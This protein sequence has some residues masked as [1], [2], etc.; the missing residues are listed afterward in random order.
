MTQY[1]RALTPLMWG[2]LSFAGLLAVLGIILIAL[3]SRGASE[4]TLFGQTFKSSNIGVSALF[5]S[6][7][8]GVLLGRRIIVAIENTTDM[9]LK[10][11]QESVLH[12]YER[13]REGLASPEQ[14]V[15]VIEEIAN[16]LDPHKEKYLSEIVSAASYSFLERTSAKSALELLQSGKVPISNLFVRVSEE[17]K[18]RLMAGLG[19]GDGS[20][21][22]KFWHAVFGLKYW[23]YINR[24]N[25]PQFSEVQSQLASAVTGKL[26]LKGLNAIQD[27]LDP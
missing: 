2:V 1:V 11:K 23:R 13:L 4:F 5:I 20:G 24:P 27:E 15:A 26:N 16:S 12:R 7:V 22:E 17:E 3:G 19:I 21:D 25:H 8:V 10:G 18:A 9:A 6:A 14:N